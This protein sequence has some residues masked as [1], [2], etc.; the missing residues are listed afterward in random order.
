MSN[1]YKIKLKKGDL[2]VVRTGKDKGKTGKV[3]GVH[4]KTNQVTVE[5]IN[6]IKKHVKANNQYPRGAVLEINKPIDVSKVGILDPTTKKA[7]RIG[8][9]IDGDK[10]VRIYKASQKEID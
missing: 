4:P 2:V 9:K 3:L 8:Y 1:L 6:I 5:N 7:S 10:K